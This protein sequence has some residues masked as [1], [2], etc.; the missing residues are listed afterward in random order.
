[1]QAVT[2]LSRGRGFIATLSVPSC[3][4][5]LTVLCR[6]GGQVERAQVG[7]PLELHFTIL[8]TDSPY[9]VFVRELI[10]KVRNYTLSHLLKWNGQYLPSGVY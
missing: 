8:D 9:E 2:V 1:M 5:Q 4:H 7:D 6:G 10:A 3:V